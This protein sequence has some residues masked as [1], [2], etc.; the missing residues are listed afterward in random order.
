MHRCHASFLNYPSIPLH[1]P[2]QHT[3]NQHCGKG[4]LGGELGQGVGREEWEGRLG[5][6]PSVSSNVC[7]CRSM[8]GYLNNRLPE[9]GLGIRGYRHFK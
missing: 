2:G 8:E 9:V 5:P 6:D 3:S 7:L 1:P 4:R